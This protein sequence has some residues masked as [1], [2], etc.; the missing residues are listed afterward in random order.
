M[1]VPIAADDL[2][3]APYY[4]FERRL[5]RFLQPAFAVLAE[6]RVEGYN[7]TL[8]VVHG[9]LIARDA[10]NRARPNVLGYLAK[11]LR[12]QIFKTH[13]AA[14]PNFYIAREQFIV[15]GSTYMWHACIIISTSVYYSGGSRARL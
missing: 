13:N 12:L 6:A 2:W 15:L 8:D 10:A 1:E 4:H 3:R 11:E 7:K 9:H 14:P 5:D